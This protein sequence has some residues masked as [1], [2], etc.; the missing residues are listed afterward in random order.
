VQSA[1]EKVRAKKIYETPVLRRLT[2]QQVK[3]V[4]HSQ[5]KNIFRTIRPDSSQP[6]ILDG[7]KKKK[8]YQ[9]PTLKKLTPEQAKLILIGH[10]TIGTEGAKDLLGLIFHDP[11]A[12]QLEQISSKQA[13]L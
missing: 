12:S 11:N 1:R 4:L 3:L 8:I 7:E 9:E 2:F 6:E 13:L 10:F 5:I